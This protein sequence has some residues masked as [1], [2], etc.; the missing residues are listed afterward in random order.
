[1]IEEE[2]KKFRN[3]L[4]YLPED[5]LRDVNE[6]IKEGWRSG[7]IWSILNTKW[8]SKVPD[9]PSRMTVEKYVVWY[10]NIL[11]SEKSADKL[12]EEAEAKILNGDIEE[13]ETSMSQV[14]SDKV[15]LSD[16]RKILELLVNKSMV[17]IKALERWQKVNLQPA[18]ENCIIRYFSEVRSLV[19]ILAKIDNDLP[20]D[21]SV[22]VNIIDSKIQPL[23]QS[24]YRV[25]Q[26][27]AP[28]K[29]ELAK[30]LLKDEL[31][32]LMSVD[33]AQLQIEKKVDETKP[34]N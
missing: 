34:E 33:T 28:E 19:E 22:I 32:R 17:R 27:I 8:K 5:V 29:V 4:L 13:F 10:Q 7:H 6:N 25:I 21:Q 1:M 12:D 16:K 3:R 24:F 23:V 9:C 31:K 26:Q 15:P 18:L 2:S 30:S 20:Q 14:S 11:D